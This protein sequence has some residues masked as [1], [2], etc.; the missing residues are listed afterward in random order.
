MVTAD[1]VGLYS[2]IP[3]VAGLEVLR[4]ALD[5]RENKKI[6]T[7][8]LTKTQVL[9]RFKPCWQRVGDSRWWGSLTMVQ[10][11]R[12]FSVNRTTKEFIILISSSSTSKSKKSQI[13]EKPKLFIPYE[14]EIPEQLKRAAKRYG[15]ELIFTRSLSLVKVTNK[16]F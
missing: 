7:D 3:E 14:K 6:S 13:L 4:K 15:L 10:A 11:K 16:H 8:N 2:S 1:V 9:C 5:N 12:L